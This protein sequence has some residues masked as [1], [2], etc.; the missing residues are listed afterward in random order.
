M[1]LPKRNI[2][3]FLRKRA[4]FIVAAFIALLTV[5]YSLNTIE[6]T[7]SKS[8]PFS[9]NTPI[10]DIRLVECFSF[11]PFCRP[12]LEFW[13]WARTSR[14]LYRSRIPWKRAYLY[15]KRPAL[16]IPGETVLVEQVYV[17][18]QLE[19]R[20]KHGIQIRYGTDGDI[21]EF[22]TLL[23]E[24]VVELREG[25]SAVLNDFIYLGQPVLLT[26]RPCETPP[27]PSIEA[28]KRKELSSVTLTYDDEE[29]KTIKILQLSDLHYSN[30]DRPCRDPYPY[31]TA[32][33]CMADAKTTAFVNELLQLEE[34]DFVLLTGDLINGDTSRDARSSLMKAVS[35]FV[36][37]NVPFAVN[38]GNHDDL[39]D[40]S[41]EELAKILSQIPGSMGLIGNV[42]GVGNFVLHSP[43]K[44]AIYVLDTKGDTSNRRLCP[45]YDAIT[46]D[47]LEWLSSKV[48]DFKY[49]PIQMAVLHIPLKEFCETEDL[50][51]AFREPCSYSICDPNTAKALKSLRIPLAIA[52]H[53]HVND[54][55]GIHPDYN[56]YFCFAGGAGFGGYGGH[57]GYVRRARVFELDPVE[58]AVRTWKR[59]E[60]PPEDRKLMLDVQTILV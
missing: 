48:A 57:G 49:E 8:G 26:Q 22:N 1:M 30:S 53:D 10:E 33:D 11:S 54:F 17:D 23:G 50:V 40:L 43:R 42:S 35:P 25:W 44:F 15:V 5:D 16:Y 52:G 56:T 34:P 47:Q 38:F 2:I 13:K 58:R 41:R 29:K 32:E 9:L 28:L 7:D 20:N 60:W 36:D 51:G 18:R 27:T 59:L 39:G 6:I 12:V 3:H 46:E 55:C 21:C 31:E 14:N 24:D 4:I 19:K 37:Y 45:G